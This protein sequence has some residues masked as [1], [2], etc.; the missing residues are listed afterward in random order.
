MMPG[1]NLAL[2]FVLELAALFGLGF[3]GWRLA[4][5]IVGIG[6]AVLAAVAWAVFA[7]PNDPSRGGKA[8]RPVSGAVRLALELLVLGGGAV[9]F[10]IAG[11]PIVGLVLAALLALHL[12]FSPQRLRWLLQ[13]K[14]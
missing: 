3:A 7:V 8:P 4:H 14:G 11:A 1:W 9:G 12:A 10:M 2:R 13:Q 5:P 6:L